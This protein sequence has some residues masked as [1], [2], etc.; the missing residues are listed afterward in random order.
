MSTGTD[1]ILTVGIKRRYERARE[2][3][4]KLLLELSRQN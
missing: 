1:R 2:P 3:S 4:L